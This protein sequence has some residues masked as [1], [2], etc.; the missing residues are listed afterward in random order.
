M[1]KFINITLTIVLLS[2]FIATM[3]SGNILKR[4]VVNGNSVPEWIDLIIHDIELEQ[5][6]EANKTTGELSNSWDKIVKKVQFSSERDEINNFSVNISR[7]QGA[8]RTQNKDDALLELYE[9]YE[10]WDE[11]GN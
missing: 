10:H 11:L 6:D 1:R 5:W 8:I 4:S 7:L 3:L 9:A 2:F